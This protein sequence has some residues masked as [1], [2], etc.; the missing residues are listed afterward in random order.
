MFNKISLQYTDDPILRQFK[1]VLTSTH[2]FTKRVSHL[3]RKTHNK[4]TKF[5]FISEYQ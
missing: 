4:N 3:Q 5:E 1:S 2:A